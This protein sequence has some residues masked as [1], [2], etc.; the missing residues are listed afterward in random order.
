MSSH[1][2]RA[3]RQSGGNKPVQL[4]VVSGILEGVACDS[5]GASGYIAVLPGH[6]PICLSCKAAQ[7]EEHG[8]R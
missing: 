4:P 6:A 8:H 2:N 5:C 3:A 7:K 1:W